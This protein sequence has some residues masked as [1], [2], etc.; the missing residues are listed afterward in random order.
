LETNIQ[1]CLSHFSLIALG[2]GSQAICA[3]VSA[4]QNYIKEDL[5]AMDKC[6]MNPGD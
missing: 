5:I 6:Y 4:I 3:A 1:N 2:F